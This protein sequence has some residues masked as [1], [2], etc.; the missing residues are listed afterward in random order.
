MKKAILIS[1]LALLIIFTPALAQNKTD[2]VR[3][4]QSYFYDAPIATSMYIEPGLDYATSSFGN[5][6]LSTMVIGAKAGYPINEK[7]E[8][9]AAIGFLNLSSNPGESESGLTDLG[10]YG[11]YNVVSQDALNFS[12]GAMLTL[13]I[14][15][16]KVGQS[17]LN[18][19]AFGAIRYALENGIVLAGNLG[20]MFYETTTVEIKYNDFGIP[21]GQVEKSDYKNYLNLGFGAIYPVNPQMNAI[22]EL[23]LKTDIN[24]MM[25]SGGV[26]YLMGKGRLRGALGLGLDDGAPDF[27]ISL[28]YGLSF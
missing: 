14:G 16:K 23:N 4:F 8:A 19:G 24:Y 15:E 25:L 26:D 13:P 5:V 7:I 9:G 3:L 22:G 2:N 12:A 10:V 18:Y 21:V 20:I 27:Q 28:G 17:N 1:A 11:R 6:D